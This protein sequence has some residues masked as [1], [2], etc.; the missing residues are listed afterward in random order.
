MS[1]EKHCQTFPLRIPL[2]ARNTAVELARRS[3]VSLNYFILVA[4]V[5]RMERIDRSRKSGSGESTRSQD[6][7]APVVAIDERN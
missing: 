2:S 7:N 3:G 5:E 4:M 1:T 6:T